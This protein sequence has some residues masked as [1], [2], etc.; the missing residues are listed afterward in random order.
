MAVYTVLE[1]EAFTRVAEAFALGS[2]QQVQPIP[3]GS[4]NTNHRVTTS[5]GRFFVRHTTARSAEELR[6]EAALLSHLTESHFPSP[7]LVR[8]RQEEP[9]LELRGGRVSVFK[10]LSG[11]ELKRSQ[12][13]ADHLERLGLELGKM[14]RITSSFGGSRDNPYSAERVR[15]W[16]EGLRGHQ[17][18]EV[19][20]V[21]E[22]LVEH[23]ARAEQERGH[24]LQPHGAIHADLFMDNVKWLAER[25]GAFFDFEMACRDAY[26]L[27]VAITLN[28]WCFEGDYKPELCRAFLRGYEDARALSPVERENLFGHALFGAVRFTV[29]R[30]RDFHLSTLPPEQLTRKDFRTYLARARALGTLGPAGFRALLGL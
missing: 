15:G 24:G 9:F 30:I 5:E 25:V 12:L 22:E 8:T 14:H 17:D 18:A 27:D 2:V 4:I 19:A 21:A 10:W 6:F 3:E 26:G 11:E 13:T 28:A 20:T 29:T 16:L 7:T 23:L 1:P